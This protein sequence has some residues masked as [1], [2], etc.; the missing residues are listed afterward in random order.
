MGR[1]GSSMVYAHNVRGGFG[2]LKLKLAPGRARFGRVY[3]QSGLAKLS[4]LLSQ[5]QAKLVIRVIF[6]PIN[7]QH[8]EFWS[9]VYMLDTKIKSAT[10]F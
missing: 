4:P 2:F 8:I 5:L 10:F 6:H 1:D 7:K 9:K 3:K